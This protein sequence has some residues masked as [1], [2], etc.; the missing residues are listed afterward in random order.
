[1]FGHP[2]WIALI[3]MALALATGSQGPFEGVRAA[4]II[5]VTGSADGTLGA[6]AGNGTCDLRE[7]VHAANDNV[8]YGECPAGQAGV[9]TIAF[10]IGPGGVVTI[11]LVD[12][13]PVIT[14]AVTIDGSTQGGLP[15][16][17]IELN[18]NSTAA[19]GLAIQASQTTVRGL[20]INRF[21]Q[22]GVGIYLATDVVIAG[23]HIGLDPAGTIDRGN[24]IMGIFVSDQASVRIGGTDPSDRNIIS[25]NGVDGV[26]VS[27]INASATILGNYIGTDVTGTVAIPNDDDGVHFDGSGSVIVG[28][29]ESGA[30]NLI[31]GNGVNGIVA[32]GVNGGATIQGNFIGTNA[33]GTGALGNQV[34]GI[35]TFTFNTLI[36]GTVPGA[37]NVISA[38]TSGV[39]IH[40]DATQTRVQGNFVGTDVTGTQHLGNSVGVRVI[41]DANTIGGTTGV[42]ADLSS[43]TGACNIISCSTPLAGLAIEGDR[44]VVQGNFIGT[45]VNGTADHGNDGPGIFID[46]TLGGSP[47]MNLIGGL[48]AGAGNLIAF[49]GQ[50]GIRIQGTGASG[51]TIQGNFIGTNPAGADLGNTGDGVRAFDSGPN[52]IGGSTGGNTIAYNDGAG[53]TDIFATGSLFKGISRNSIF[54]NGGLGID[55]GADGVTPND[56]GDV[57]TGANDLQNFPVLSSAVVNA[58]TRIEGSLDSQSDVLYRIEFFASATCDPSGYGEGQRFLG[59]TNVTTDGN[60]HAAFS[61]TVASAASSGE[62]ITATAMD[63]AF[64]TSEFSAC[65]PVSG[66]GDPCP[67]PAMIA[68]GPGANGHVVCSAGFPL[69]AGQFALRAPGTLP[70]SVTAVF[71]W[72]NAQ[73]LFK[74][75]FRG[76][77]E[78]FQTL[79]SLVDGRYYFFQSSGS[80]SFANTGGSSTLAPSGTTSINPTVAGANGVVWAGGDHAMNTFNT[81]ASIDDATAVF[82]WNNVQQ[83][84]DFWFRGFPDGFQTLTAGIERGKYYFF[85]SPANQ[86]IP[87]D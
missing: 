40:A 13:L 61:A 30:G 85:Q 48:V 51:N 6:L 50:D 4:A 68:L 52:L 39:M 56:P 10:D 86:Q 14:E 25:G 32:S 7:A 72:N 62:A 47:S 55:L 41:G 21:V 70:D 38:N 22:N 18:G 69:I 8:P 80:G 42:T 73:Q 35:A 5:T 1:M 84:F 83:R 19:N 15:T 59:F 28:G 11:T 24:A 60:G 74:F 29:T 16:P 3:A 65:I 46:A 87:M 54:S 26:Y 31:S 67:G 20:A 76:F 27:G 58:G 45:D 43:C 71:E 77:P 64:N 66:G 17:M 81:Y 53:V 63:P 34:A 36:G 79:A 44:N 33:S 75:W 78:G 57:D 37:R 82:W 23:N 9:D 2:K 12:G 49:S